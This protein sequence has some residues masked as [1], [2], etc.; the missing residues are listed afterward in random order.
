M[1]RRFQ[2]LAFFALFGIVSGT[3]AARSEQAPPKPKQEQKKQPEKTSAA[4]L[5]GC[6]DEQNGKY[7]MI[8][9]RTRDPIA[10]LAA[11]GFE[12]EGFAKHVGHTVT[13]RGISSPG[14]SRPLFRVRSIEPI[15]DS[16]EPQ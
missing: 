4:S 11:E 9:N 8:D 5:T 16:C 3:T 15:S 2:L 12:L 14:E 13:I 10:D 7:L 1:Y 6:I